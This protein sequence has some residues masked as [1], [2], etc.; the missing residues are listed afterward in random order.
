MARPVLTAA[1]LLAAA[2]IAAGC[3]SNSIQVAKDDPN[4][5]GAVLFAER[6][7]SCHTLEAAGTQGSSTDVADSEL[8][9][10][11]N[12]N[13][14]SETVDDVIF[15]IANGGFSGAI[16]PANIATGPEA[17]AIA[18]FLAKY[19]GKGGKQSSELEAPGADSDSTG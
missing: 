18:E 13:E 15:A 2:A 10:G 5:Q 11:P 17:R 7:G 9:D 6:C 19:A 4:R 3:G 14:R 12:F 16:M 1:F 8:V